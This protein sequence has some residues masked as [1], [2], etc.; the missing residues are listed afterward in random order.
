MV[1]S[2]FLRSLETTLERGVQVYI[3]YGVGVD[4]TA[5]ARDRDAEAS[6]LRLA[7]KYPNLIVGRLGTRT[8]KCSS[9]TTNTSLS[10]ASTSS[11]SVA[12]Q[13]CHIAMSVGCWWLFPTQ[14]RQSLLD[15]NRV[16]ATLPRMHELQRLSRRLGTCGGRGTPPRR[17]GFCLSVGNSSPSSGYALN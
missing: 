2:L 15:S 10:L 11:L 16:S 8:R 7:E 6:L 17:E 4:E 1:D 14:L 3:G 9:S 13:T 5:T 12:I